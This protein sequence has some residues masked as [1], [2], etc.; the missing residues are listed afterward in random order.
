MAN[1]SGVARGKRPNFPK[2][3]EECTCALVD[4]MKLE[5][6]GTFLLRLLVFENEISVD[7]GKYNV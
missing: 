4:V 6:L 3:A 1:I 5:L 7:T 2:P